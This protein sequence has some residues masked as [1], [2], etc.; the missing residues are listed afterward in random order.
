MHI[1]IYTHI[2]VA[3]ALDLLL[4]LLLGLPPRLLLPI[5][6]YGVYNSIV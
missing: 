5:H 2:H 4:G 3:N 6:A 1:Y